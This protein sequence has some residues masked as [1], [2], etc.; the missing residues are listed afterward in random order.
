MASYK[1]LLGCGNFLLLLSCLA[2]SKMTSSIQLHHCCLLSPS[3]ALPSP[4]QTWSSLDP[5]ESHPC[6]SNGQEIALSSEYSFTYSLFSCYTRNTVLRVPNLQ[7]V[8]INDYVI[9]VFHYKLVKVRVWVIHLSAE[10]D[11]NWDDIHRLLTLCVRYGVSTPCWKLFQIA[12]ALKVFN[13]TRALDSFFILT[14][15]KGQWM[16][17]K[18]FTGVCLLKMVLFI[19]FLEGLFLYFISWY[20]SQ[21]EN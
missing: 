17:G 5:S 4:Q 9:E 16:G 1:P 8:T 11:L 13:S 2:V 14:S 19:Y 21:Q 10:Q 20:Q 3:S 7:W 18:G 6:W 15:F 12:W